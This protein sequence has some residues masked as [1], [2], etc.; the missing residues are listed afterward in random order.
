MRPLQNR[1]S[2]FRQKAGLTLFLNFAALCRDAVTVKREFFCGFNIITIRD[3][4]SRVIPLAVISLTVLFSLRAFGG[5][6]LADSPGAAD[7][8]LFDGQ[9]AAPIFVETNDDRAV[10]R[11]AGDL[12]EDVQR[13][14]GTKPELVQDT[15]GKMNVVI[16]GTLGQSKTIDRLVAEG[17]LDAG[18]VRGQWESYVLQV[19]KNPLP[20]V[21]QALV[22]TGSDRRGTIY[23]IYQLSE[24]IGVSPWYWWADVPVKRR[25]S[26][27]IHGDVF[28]Q[29]P[30]AVKYRGI[31]LNDEDWG[32]RPW[33]AKTFDPETGNIGPKTYAKIFELLLRLR[34]NY[35]W[36]AM[37]P[38]TRA[39]NFYPADKE[40]ADAYGIVMGSSH[41]E[42]MLRD[43]VDEWERD[44]HGDYNFVTNPA[45]VLK[46]WEQR[47]RENGKF[48]NV[49]T[50]GM[51]G[52]HDSGMPGGGTPRERAARLHTIIAGQR[53]MLGR[54]V[55]TN[56]AAVPQIFCP[57]KE[58]LEL[59]RLAP[60]IPDDITLVWPDD[61]YGYI[62]EFSD[63][64]ERRRSGGAG[65][66]YHVSYYGRP[67]DYLWLCSTPPALIAEEMTKAYDYGADR[68]W[69]LNVGD[70][71][72][73][74]L[75]IEFFLKLAWNPHSWNGTNTYE[76][77]EMQLARDFG[78]VPQRGTPELTSILAEYYRLNFQRKPEH[79]GFPTNN[80]FSTTLNGDEAGR[81]LEAWQKLSARVDTVEKNIP[82]ES[83][84][85]FFELVGY[86]VR[87]AALANE[88]ILAP[89]KAQPAQDEIQRLTDVYNTQIASGKWRYMMSSNPRGQ[90]D[91]G[92]PKIPPG[93]MAVTTTNAI[94]AEAGPLPPAETNFPGADFVEDNHCVVME[95]EHASAFIPG[96]DARWRKIT[97][98][99]YNGEV[100]S[101]FPTLVP[102]RDTPEKILAESPCLQY[103]IWLQHPGDWKFT[104]RALPTFSI[105]TGK[106]QRYAIAVDDAPPQIVSLPAAQSE[107]DRHWQENV[108]RN[109]ALTTSVHILVH[110]GLHTLKLWMVDPGI[111]IDAI[112]G[113]GGDGPLG[114]S[115]PPEARNL[116]R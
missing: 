72:P 24:L 106:P 43:N 34:A 16:I 27:A 82:V 20:G 26:V 39:F 15:G 97:G 2:G 53:E 5:L 52:I 104:V 83:Q 1:R 30:P 23:G 85:A 92:I 102:V 51:R 36:P 61:N 18:G 86:P 28:K 101:V 74:E 31:F 10:I 59:Y 90:V 108:L 40:L 88:K 111:V 70:L 46:Y 50:L 93:E 12:V 25:N 80:L 115:W 29:G 13:V 11:A 114:Y 4:L 73:A 76:L 21:E 55:N 66:Y 58:V 75:D 84:D 63:A 41:C 116:T 107:T 113:D 44:G 67:R 78:P 99:G 98:L 38:D 96:R 33:A 48:E 91:L 8:I 110:P 81:R 79:M 17:K 68:V 69:I 77:L 19:V 7:F 35:L 57:Y 42:Q 94:P 6:S 71:K 65:V 14:T 89:E 49:Y 32:L 60:D 64:R 109:A 47:V 37:H 62:R 22:I 54:L 9:N 95:A 112:I 56:V 87:A 105:E 45:G 103:K 100:V 3:I